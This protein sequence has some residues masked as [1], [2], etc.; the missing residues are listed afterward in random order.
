MPAKQASPP[1]GS[2]CQPPVVADP[3]VVGEGVGIGVTLG[4]GI[5]EGVTIAVLLEDIMLGVGV[6][7][8]KVA[9]PVTPVGFAGCA[10]PATIKVATKQAISIIFAIKTPH[11]P[12]ASLS[13]H[14]LPLAS[15]YLISLSGGPLPVGT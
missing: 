15:C 13:N 14:S 9:V 10:H 2:H 7:L 11:W 4:S 8:V 12:T 1:L 6:E 5:E 3:A